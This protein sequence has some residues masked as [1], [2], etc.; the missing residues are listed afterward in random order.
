M[1]GI[2][3]LGIRKS[4]KLIIRD[5]VMSVGDVMYTQDLHWERSSMY[6]ALHRV[7]H[8]AYIAKRYTTSSVQ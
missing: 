6:R 8:L 4:T 2:L 7:D 1:L 3:S 5:L